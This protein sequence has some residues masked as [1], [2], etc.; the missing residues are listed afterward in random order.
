M[1]KY[2]YDKVNNIYINEYGKSLKYSDGTEEE[3]KLKS[4][5]EKNIDLSTFSSDLPM[6]MNSWPTEYHFSRKRHLVIRQFDIKKGDTVLEL[7]SGCGSVTRYLAEIGAEVTSVEGTEARAAV[8][9]IRCK[10]FKNVEIFVDNINE[11]NTEKKFDW[12]LMIG[13][14]EYSPK[15]SNYEEPVLEYLNTVHKFLKPEGNFVLA[16]EN[17]IGIKY[18]N[19]ATEDHNGKPFFGPEDLYD[20]KDIT[21]WGKKELD[22]NLRKS[23]FKS[24][25]FYSSFPDY[26]L[27]TLLIN[28]S[29]DKENK[30]RTE[31]L[32]HYMKSHDYTGND[33]RFFEESFFVSSLRKNGLLSNF[34]NSFVVL[35]SNL[36]GA[37]SKSQLADYYS[38]GRKKKFCTHTLFE[39]EN[40]SIVV[41][42][43]LMYKSEEPPQF[44]C[45]LFD[46]KIIKFSQVINSKSEYLNGTLLGYK[47]SKAVKR[48]NI[49]EI[50]QCLNIWIN[51][52]LNNFNFYDKNS[53]EQINKIGQLETNLSETYIEGSAVDCGMHNIV[54]DGD[55]AKSF[56]LEWQANKPIPFAWVLCRNIMV[57]LRENYKIMANINK[58]SL[59]NYIAREMKMIV[60]DMDF[61]VS[62]EMEARFGV[63]ITERERI[64]FL[65]LSAMFKP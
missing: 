59:L 37:K 28:E 51:H 16:I 4:I 2:T 40:N 19:G 1:K 31:E 9:G 43:E 35:C 49:D 24:I 48:S 5:V 17:K 20:G 3:K 25:D 15:Y 8:N 14:L 54:V 13:V 55:I 22:S 65:P 62:I 33:R 11:F 32:L 12:I 29:S 58:E 34:A 53:G 61:K 42:K 41:R 30:F 64:D 50:H 60:S 10:E 27:P 56:D 23:G 57:S 18:L 45:E 52:L 47:F 38:I 46:K 26:K 44:E 39:R 36:E 7:G 6:E 63:N 21:T